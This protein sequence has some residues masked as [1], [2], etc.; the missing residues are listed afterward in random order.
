MKELWSSAKLDS[1][2]I[3]PPKSL[4]ILDEA[5]TLAFFSGD[6][7]LD[8]Y[9]PLCFNNSLEIPGSPWEAPLENP[10]SPWESP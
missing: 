8:L 5:S 6:P 3:P 2:G 10:G 9:L 4:M 7:P 1:K